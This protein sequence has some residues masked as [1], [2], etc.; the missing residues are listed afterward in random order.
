MPARLSRASPGPA[1]ARAPW[2]TSPASCCIDRALRRGALAILLALCAFEASA[3]LS[4]TASIL[5]D[6]RYRGISLSGGDPAAQLG[7][8]YDDPS[9]VYAGFFASSVQFAISA[10]RELQMV[11][12]A[13]YARRLAS[14]WSAEVGAEYAT[15]TGPGSYDY[16]ELYVG[17][18]GEQL[19]ARL[20]YA[21]R[22]FGRESGAFY[23]ELNGAQALTDRIRV[24][25]HVGMLVNRGDYPQYGP[26]DRRLVDGRLGVAVDIEALTFQASWVGVNSANTGYPVAHGRKN[27]AVVALSWTF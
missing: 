2:P 27:T 8:A 15:F 5:S 4:A 14:G 11:P 21:P 19:S 25:A 24:L 12:Y 9:G 13:G 16:A 1:R 26:S 18:A 7:L 23:A 20:Y 6:Y 10:H 3:Q 17:I 22:Y